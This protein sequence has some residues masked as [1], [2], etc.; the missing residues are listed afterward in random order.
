M[1]GA[2]RA[3]RRGRRRTVHDEMAERRCTLSSWRD[4]GL[5]LAGPAGVAGGMTVGG[6]GDRC[7]RTSAALRTDA[8]AAGPGPAVSPQKNANATRFKDGVRRSIG[9]E[10]RRHSPR[11]GQE[12]RFTVK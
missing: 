7:V 4:I 10:A 3:V 6:S 11:A 1:E 9:R 5:V 2:G 12:P 8:A